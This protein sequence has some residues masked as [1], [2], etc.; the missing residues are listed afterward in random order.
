[1]P[2]IVFYFQVHQPYRLN[3]NFRRDRFFQDSLVKNLEK[4]Y[5]TEELNKDVMQRVAKKCYLPANKTWLKAIDEHKKEK[6]LWSP[7]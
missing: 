7:R 1:M 5:F 3:Q 2:S 6:D 4:L